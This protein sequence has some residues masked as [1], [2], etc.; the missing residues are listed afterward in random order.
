M[1]KKNVGKKKTICIILTAF[2]VLAAVI[3]AFTRPH[4]AKL[5]IETESYID[6][7]SVV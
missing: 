4:K 3:C 2:I 6:R 7:K 5:D 1:E